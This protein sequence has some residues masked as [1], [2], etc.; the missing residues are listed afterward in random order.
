MKA[1]FLCCFMFSLVAVAE[2]AS[3]PT[4]QFQSGFSGFG[5]TW[6]ACCEGDAVRY[7][8]FSYGSRPRGFGEDPDGRWVKVSGQTGRH[9]KA[10]LV[11]GPR[12]ERDLFASPE[13]IYQIGHDGHVTTYNERVSKKDLRSFMDSRPHEYTAEALLAF[14]HQLHPD[15]Q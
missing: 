10:V 7:V 1:S 11:W 14:V 9:P 6:D 3:I 15:G 12:D 4:K 2:P 13:Q 8:V 5:Y